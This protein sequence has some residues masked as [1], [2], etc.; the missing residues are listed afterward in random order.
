MLAL[1]G[2]RVIDL[3]RNIA[4]PYC[5]QILADLGAEV[6]KVEEAVHG[7]VVREDAAPPGSPVRFSAYWLANNRNKGSM[8]LDLHNPRAIEVLRDLVA[9]SDVVIENFAPRTRSQLGLDEGWG[10]QANPALIWASISAYG[11]SGPDRDRGGQDLLAQARSGLL[12]ITGEPSGPPMKSG[13]SSS[14]YL[15][16]LH[17]AV[18]ILAAVVQRQSTERGQLVDVSLLDSTVACLDGYP[19]WSSMA[20]IVPGRRGNLHLAG[21]PYYSVY[22]CKDGYIAIAGTGPSRQRLFRLIGRPDLLPPPSPE[23]QTAHGKWCDDVVG[24][25]SAWTSGRTFEELEEALRKIGSGYEPVRTMDH[26][27]TD[28][29]LVAREMILTYEDPRYGEVSSIGNPIHLEDSPVTV[30]R[31]PPELG[32]DNDYVLQDLLRYDERTIAELGEDGA[33]WGR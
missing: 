18:G 26:I 32:V 12:S 10:K 21:L 9:L 8:T 6:I 11:R 4:A 14:D 2:I 15:A 31:S 25:I 29:Q 16:G 28:P 17:L 24:A 27:W 22:P 23:D 19:L 30:R 13:N 20:G 1:E 5:A 7:V 33:L 3:S